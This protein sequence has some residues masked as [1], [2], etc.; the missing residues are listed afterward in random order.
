MGKKVLAIIWNE[1]KKSQHFSL[2]VHA[3]YRK[4]YHVIGKIS[5][6]LYK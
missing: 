4:I 5:L 1:V 3:Y 6:S 2:C